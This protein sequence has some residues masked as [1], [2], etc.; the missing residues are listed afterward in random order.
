M[1]VGFIIA[2]F[3]LGTY[4]GMSQNRIVSFEQGDFQTALSKAERQKKLLFVDFYTAWCGPCKKMSK[5]VFTNNQVADYFNKR[6]ISFKLDA[7]KGE[8]IELM[9]K[10]QV[11]AF[12]TF[13]ILN[14]L[15]EEVLRTV[16]ALPYDLF[17]EKVKKGL[18]P[19]RSSKRLKERYE[20]G[21]R[22]SQL[23]YD[24]MGQL[25]QEENEIGGKK[26]MDSYF[27]SLSKK[28][29]SKP[30]NFF[31][32]K[33]FF[34][35]DSLENP[36]FQF[37]LANKERFYHT[38]GKEKVD[39]LLEMWISAELMYY[40]SNF[41]FEDNTFDKDKYRRVKE[42]VQKAA[43]F[44]SANIN[45]LIKIADARVEKGI[46]SYLDVCI[47]EF[48]KL[49][50]KERLVTMINLSGIKKIGES[51]LQ[52]KTVELLR[53]YVS[54]V[55]GFNKKVIERVIAELEA[56]LPFTFVAYVN[57]AKSGKVIFNSFNG[58]NSRM[59]T[60]AFDNNKIIMQITEKDTLKAVMKIQSE[61]VAYKNS[62]GMNLYPYIN[63]WIVPGEKAEVELLLERAKPPVVK[64]K[65]G[66]KILKDFVELN[67]DIL[68]NID[69]EYKQLTI[70]NNI[71][72]GDIREYT[73]ILQNVMK[74]DK[75]AIIEFVR[76]HPDS[77]VSVRYL[78]DNY[79]AFD[80]N[81]SE[82][83]YHKCSTS[84]Q[85]S[86]IGKALYSKL[87]AGRPYR[88]GVVAPE[89]VKKDQNGHNISLSQ[90]KGKCV[91]LDFWGSWCGPCRA[92]HSHL[93]ELNKKYASQ[94]VIF[95]NVAQ[96]NEKELEKAKVSWLT[97]IKE[98]KLTWTQILN[99]E[100][101]EV[102]N[103]LEL[104]H[105]SAFPTKILIAPDGKIAARIVGASGDIEPSLEVLFKK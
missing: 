62:R 32:Y 96:E 67:Y 26:V 22:N 81:E 72:G 9:K 97:A 19:N 12:P 80:E 90:F 73:E 63:F 45:S 24:Y 70:N 60:V 82:I 30:E 68:A 65:K 40:V 99:N 43:L 28:Q 95:I 31:L 41:H 39:S 46:E 2:L 79:D 75:A 13:L 69:K 92:S 23:I 18:D 33:R 21:E 56:P 35:S 5:E 36:K 76:N 10:F 48:P 51:V 3:C 7:E 104:F 52:Q 105:I 47:T 58:M 6:F 49:T 57:G 20:K 42:W 84:L 4:C 86:S 17:L 50:E 89:F 98:D 37:L 1:K 94:G 103:L 85:N 88:I 66:G 78:F 71:R 25:F 77:Y 91:V 29:K 101:M 83:I 16:G 8:G 14:G 38:V 55:Q 15:G 64:W 44:D 11:K 61:E 27:N 102:C 54:E 87:L 53:N 34:L 100:G 59:D 74:K 93:R